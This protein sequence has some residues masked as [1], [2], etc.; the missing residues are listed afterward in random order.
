MA[1]SG[2]G[3]CSILLI[4][5]KTHTSQAVI[6]KHGQRTINLFLMTQLYFGL[7]IKTA[8]VVNLCGCRR[9]H[10]TNELCAAGYTQGA[11]APVSSQPKQEHRQTTGEKKRRKTQEIV[12]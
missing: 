8:A 3:V 5:R 4:I 7:A 1:R 12:I 9:G 2:G 6:L 10:I 11:P